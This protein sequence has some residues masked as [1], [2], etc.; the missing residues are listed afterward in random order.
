[1]IL[2]CMMMTDGFHSVVFMH[3]IIHEI[4]ATKVSLVFDF[5]VEARHAEACCA[6]GDDGGRSSAG[7]PLKNPSG[8]SM[9][10]TEA[11]G[12][13]GQSSSAGHA[14]GQGV[15]DDQVAVGEVAIGPGRPGQAV[16]AGVLIGV[17]PGRESFPGIERRHPEMVGQERSPSQERGTREGERLGRLGRAETVGHRLAHRVLVMVIHDPPE[18]RRGRVRVSLGLGFLEECSGFRVVAAVE[19]VIGP[20]RALRVFTS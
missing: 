2:P 8:R 10:P 7:L 5:P 15:P 3:I 9:N 4:H 13:T 18:S 17:V 6:E 14:S 1:M 16:A 20:C 19:R 11:T 12:I